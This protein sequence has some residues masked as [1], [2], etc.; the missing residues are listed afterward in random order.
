MRHLKLFL[1]E[2]AEI[3]GDVIGHELH[4]LGRQS[5]QRLLGLRMRGRSKS[6]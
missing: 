6:E 1:R 5:E 3:L 4:A 2:E